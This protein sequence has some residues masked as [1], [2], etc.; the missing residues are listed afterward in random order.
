MADVAWQSEFLELFSGLDY[1]FHHL[2]KLVLNFKYI[3][4]PFPFVIVPFHLSSLL[5]YSLV[6]SDFLA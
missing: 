2:A 6:D 1:I 5:I 3:P 4:F